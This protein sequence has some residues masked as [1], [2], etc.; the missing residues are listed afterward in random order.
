M[1][2]WAPTYRV[3]EFYENI[4]KLKGWTWPGMHKSFQ[5]CRTLHARFGLRASS[6]PGVLDEL[7]RKSPKNERGHRSNRLHQWLTEDVGNPMML[8][9][10]LH[11]LIMFQ[12]LAIASG[13]G[14]QRFVR[15]VD[16]LLPKK[17]STLELPFM[18]SDAVASG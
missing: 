11:S 17:G 9:Q 1:P 18:T 3:P 15:M 2:S 12:R 4:Y 8:A 14:W 16:H 7:E 5:R 6:T 10:H 13:F